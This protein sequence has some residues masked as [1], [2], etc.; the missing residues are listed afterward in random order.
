MP[1]TTE[2]SVVIMTGAAGGLGGAMTRGLLAA[3]RRVVAVDVT[4]TDEGLAALTAE[5]GRN[6]T[7]GRLLTLEANVRSTAACEAVVAKGREHFGRIDALVNCAGLGINFVPDPAG[8]FG[9]PRFYD[10][11]VD[12]WEAVMDTN[13]NGPFRLAHAVAPLLAAQGWGRIINV[14][15]GYPTMV[16]FSP[17]GSSKAALEAATVVWSNDLAG[18][19][20]TV[21]VLI[22]GAAAN[23]PMVP[24][25]VVADRS[26]L[27][28]PDVMVAPVVWLTSP[29][30]DGVT[31]R[32]FIGQDWNPEA[33]D[34][35]NLAR[36]ER[37]GWGIEAPTSRTPKLQ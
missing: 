33:S 24:H 4:T 18:T 25:A 9:A 1:N 32:R 27:V 16:K 5:A 35:Q 36:A 17:Y 11:P 3:G 13:V 8:G 7:A 10:V 14:A 6:G 15:T 2:D 28:Q 12:Y 29:R 37:A 22:P 19:G 34:A 31:G 30:S 26:R 23:T 21:N 20:V